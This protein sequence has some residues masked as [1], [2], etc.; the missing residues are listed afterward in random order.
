MGIILPKHCWSIA[1]I[2]ETE[3]ADF[4]AIFPPVL[5]RL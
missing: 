4:K 2:S 3:D 5:L 1:E